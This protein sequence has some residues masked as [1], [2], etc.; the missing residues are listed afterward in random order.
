M[1]G[2][3]NT[4]KVVSRITSDSTSGSDFGLLYK[5]FTRSPGGKV[6]LERTLKAV[7]D[8]D[9][10]RC[11]NYLSYVFGKGGINIK[12]GSIETTPSGF[13]QQLSHVWSLPSMAVGPITFVGGPPGHIAI[14]TGTFGTMLKDC[15]LR[16]VHTNNTQKL[17][18]LRNL[19]LINA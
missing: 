13:V 2:T 17:V 16:A 5:E 12:V 6:I 9:C 8:L 18:I 3:S 14:H 4:S 7:D 1:G 11:V 10:G 15:I 19:C